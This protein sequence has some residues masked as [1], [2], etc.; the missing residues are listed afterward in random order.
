MQ[1]NLLLTLVLIS[2]SECSVIRD[3]V[4]P[5]S[6]LPVE[7]P[8]WFC[9]DFVPPSGPVEE[10]SQ[11]HWHNVGQT[12]LEKQLKKRTLNENIAKNLII[13][14]GDGMGLSTQTATRIFMGDDSVELAFEKFAYSGLAKT[15]C[16]NYQ[17]SDSA[18]TANA[19]LTG[20]K[21]NYGVIGWDGNVNLYN[22]SAGTEADKLHSI[23]KWAQDDGRATGIVTTT[24]ITHATPAAAYASVAS[25]Y[26]ES[27]EGMP[28][29]C[30]DIADQLVTGQ[31]G[32][33][34]T[35]VLGGGLRH[36]LPNTVPGGRRTDNRNLIE[37]WL[38]TKRQKLG[39]SA[40]FVATRV[41]I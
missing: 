1:L 24:R 4:Q 2:L 35:V 3:Q 18:C 9:P 20:A 19:I 14:I 32:E 11:T 23:L 31:V 26:H 34:L 16:V 40:R 17:V 38:T 7:C 36:F 13:F 27:D 37:E 12:V 39:V 10:Q 33:K 29:G 15:Y 6:G 22:C 28:A 41:G 5:T 25:R 21:T 8:W 30:T